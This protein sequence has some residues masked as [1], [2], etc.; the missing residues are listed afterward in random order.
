MPLALAL[1]AGGSFVARGF[2]GEPK[3]LKDTLKEGITHKGMALVDVLQPCVTFNRVNTFQ[4]FRDRI[5]KLADTGYEPSDRMKAIEKAVEWDE[6][7]P[8][9]VI[10]KDA[11]PTLDDQL[12]ALKAGPLVKQPLERD[13]RPIMER[14]F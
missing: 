9:G 12:P 4:W 10:Y 13:I 7:I 14:F 8:L 6:K 1:S 2:A 11:K 5:Y 3:H